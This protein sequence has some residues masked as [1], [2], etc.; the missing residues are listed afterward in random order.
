MPD[1]DDLADHDDLLQSPF[2]DQRYAV[3]QNSSDHFRN[4]RA[5]G[6][7][8]CRLSALRSRKASRSSSWTAP[9]RRLQS[10]SARRKIAEVDADMNVARIRRL[11]RP[12][13]RSRKPRATISRPSMSWRAKQELQRRNPGNVPFREIERLQVRAQ[14]QLAAISGR[15]RHEERSRGTTC[16]GASRGESH[17]RSRTGAGARSIWGRRS[18]VRAWTGA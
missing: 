3:L 4:D 15:D 1:P 7:G 10:R 11:E 5:R 16:D 14:G 6:R 18:F 17:R 12:T 8:L 13:P 9:N 2:D